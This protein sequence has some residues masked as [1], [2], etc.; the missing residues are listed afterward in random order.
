MHVLVPAVA[1]ASSFSEGDDGD[2]EDD[3]RA[4]RGRRSERRWK[5]PLS[6]PRVTTR[7]EG[8]NIDAGAT[9]AVDEPRFAHARE[10]SDRAA[11]R[12]AVLRG[13]SAD[14]LACMSAR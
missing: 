8:R 3:P 11:A 13:T 1:F 2:D 5:R 7:L 9:G 12:Q 10:G 14:M 6:S 4:G